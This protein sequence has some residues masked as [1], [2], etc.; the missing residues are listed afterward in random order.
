MRRGGEEDARR[1][2]FCPIIPYPAPVEKRRAENFAKAG[3]EAEQVPLGYIGPHGVRWHFRS[4]NGASRTPPPT[5][6][7]KN[8][9]V[10]RGGMRSCRPTEFYWHLCVGRGDHTPPRWTCTG[11]DNRSVGAGVPDGPHDERTKFDNRSVGATLPILL[12]TM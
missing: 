7:R 3:Y 10:I 2:L 1:P 6:G 8:H 11:F 9:R 5:H 4:S 12:L